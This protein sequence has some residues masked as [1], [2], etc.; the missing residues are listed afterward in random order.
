MT[1]TRKIVG[2]NWKSE[3]TTCEIFFLRHWQNL[4]LW[5]LD[6]EI[7][8]VHMKCKKIVVNHASGA[9]LP[10]TC[11]KQNHVLVNVDH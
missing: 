9:K 5:L 10:K 3:V 2:V 1:P 6:C 4:N 7:L 11:V 8:K